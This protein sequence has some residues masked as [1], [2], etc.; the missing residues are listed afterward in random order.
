LTLA[1]LERLNGKPFKLSGFDK[2]NV[3]ALSNWNGGTLA[4][5]AGGCKIGVS[6]RAA[7]T[8]SASAISALPSDRE[9]NSADAALRAVNPTVSEILVAY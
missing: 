7:S 5:P 3:A 6:L 8:A 1:E 4:S 9:F 2:N